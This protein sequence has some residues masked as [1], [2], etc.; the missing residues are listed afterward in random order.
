M[1]AVLSVSGVPG[2]TAVRPVGAT[3]ALV[4]VDDAAHALALSLWLRSRV[5][6]LDVVPAAATVL[7]DGCSAADLHAVVGHWTGSADT[8]DG[9]LVEVPVVYDGPDLAGVAGLLGLTVDEVVAAHTETEHVVA[10]CG[11]APGFGYLAGSPWDVPRLASPRAW[12]EPGSVGLAA[13]WTG[14]YPTASPGGW[15]L[16]GRT[17][18]VLWDPSA[19]RPALFEPGTRV[20][21]V[22]V[23][24]LGG[25]S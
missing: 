17:D 18:V 22:Q 4:E 20:R 8:P 19:P 7:V 21:F 2:V 1:T 25:G 6:A 16:V 3:A 24:A 23:A 12:V 14:V 9:P 11:F 13:S 10:F 5:A 15:Q